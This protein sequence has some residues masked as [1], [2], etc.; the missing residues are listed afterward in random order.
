MTAKSQKKLWENEKHTIVQR[1]ERHA[2][3]YRNKGI[4]ELELC[5]FGDF[6][7]KE[8]DD[9]SKLAARLSNSENMIELE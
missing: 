1:F 7:N 2:R 3:E 5:P 4:P 8:E 9:D 6:E